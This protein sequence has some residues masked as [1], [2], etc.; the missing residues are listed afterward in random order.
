MS[1][2]LKKKSAIEKKKKKVAPESGNKAS[3]ASDISSGTQKVSA[4][5]LPA[6][7]EKKSTL[8]QAAEPGRL[9][10]IIEF[11]KEVKLELDKVIW[12]PKNLI[13][14]TTFVVILFVLIVSIF[15]G[16]FDFGLSTLVQVILT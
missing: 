6:K 7:S 10:K 5:P 8:A 11:F 15:L 3:N 16:L 4:K 13:T 14:R 2:Q 1:R 9:Q 12:P